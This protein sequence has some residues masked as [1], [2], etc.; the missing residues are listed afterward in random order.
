MNREKL[1]YFLLACSAVTA[2]QWLNSIGLLCGL[3][4]FWLSGLLPRE[5]LW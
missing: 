2:D 3:A 4:G 5:D 1:G